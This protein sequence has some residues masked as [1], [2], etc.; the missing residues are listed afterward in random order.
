MTHT[1]KTDAQADREAVEALI[2]NADQNTKDGWNHASTFKRSHPLFIAAV[3]Y[4]GWSEEK[5]DDLFI[6]A[7]TFE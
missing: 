4:L 1:L 6:L 5:I 7:A 2:T 3:E